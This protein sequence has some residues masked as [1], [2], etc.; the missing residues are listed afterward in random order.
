[1][2][3]LIAN[4]DRC[5]VEAVRNLQ[6]AVF[7]RRTR[8]G[9]APRGC[10]RRRVSA[11]AIAVFLGFAMPAMAVAA[12]PTPAPSLGPTGSGTVLLSGRVVDPAGRPVRHVERALLQQWQWDARRRPGT[13]PPSLQET[14]SVAADGTFTVPLA[15]WGTAADP[16]PVAISVV[17]SDRHWTD[18]QGCD[19]FMLI[20]GT[21]GSDVELA[22]PG[23]QPP[24]AVT[25]VVAAGQGGT[26]ANRRTLVVPPATSTD[27]PRSDGSA[28]PALGS[29]SIV[30]GL[31]AWLSIRH[32]LRTINPAEASST[33]ASAPPS[34]LKKS[35][36]AG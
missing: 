13:K 30:A 25:V 16:S 18:R 22:D 10:Y 3:A 9:P 8:Q 11:A 36:A 24:S 2:N 27:P 21:G 7:V 29:I 26:C 31:A 28:P 17:V 1:M 34:I 32:R 33:H 4:L 14:F 35:K 19:E 5:N 15:A 12:S 23:A 6:H 20:S